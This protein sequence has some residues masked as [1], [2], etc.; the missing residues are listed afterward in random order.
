MLSAIPISTTV[1][2]II[3][4]A[5]ATAV[6]T[7]LIW[8][9]RSVARITKNQ[10]AIHDQVM[11]VPEVGYPSMRDQFTEVREHLSR[12][13]LTLVNLE[14]E[15]QDNSGSS[16]KDAV[17]VVNKDLQEIKK[18]VL[19]YINRNNNS[20]DDLDKKINELD[21]KFEIHFKAI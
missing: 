12:Q 7:L 3:I 9:G 20:L 18:E 11:G 4:Y 14:H 21:K 15:V 6:G 13:D 5:V 17:K 8:I 10:S 2:T 16:L 19:P 1:E